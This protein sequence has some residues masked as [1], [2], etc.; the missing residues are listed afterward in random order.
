[1][2]FGDPGKTSSYTLSILPDRK[3]MKLATIVLLSGLMAG[4]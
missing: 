3:A 2:S 1:M 4:M